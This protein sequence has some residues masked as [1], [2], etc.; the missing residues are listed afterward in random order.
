MTA[1]CALFPLPN[2]TKYTTSIQCIFSKKCVYKIEVASPAIEKKKNETEN[3]KL[4][5]EVY[6]LKKNLTLR[7]QYLAKKVS[8]HVRY[9]YGVFPKDFK[10]WAFKHG[11]Q[12]VSETIRHGDIWEYR[13]INFIWDRFKTLAN[14]HSQRG[15]HSRNNGTNKESR[16]WGL[17]DIG[18]YI[19]TITVPAAQIIRHFG[20]GSVTAVEAVPLQALLLRKRI[21]QNHL[22]NILVV[23]QAISDKPG[24]NVL[25]KMMSKTGEVPPS[26]GPRCHILPKLRQLLR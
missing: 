2:F 16:K 9:K 15:A 4:S 6:N 1:F 13:Y 25:L 21:E 10:L 23:R 24:L 20:Q 5:L 12:Y 17:L 8:K 3:S 14:L 19:G 26:L 18:A 11:D 7:E 22:D